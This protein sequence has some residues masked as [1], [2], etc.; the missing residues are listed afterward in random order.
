MDSTL[1][2][3]LHLAI[4]GMDQDKFRCPRNKRNLTSCVNMLFWCDYES[5]DRGWYN[6]VF[7]DAGLTRSRIA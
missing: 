6:I 4:D 1:P 7:Q 3:L 5:L 2:P